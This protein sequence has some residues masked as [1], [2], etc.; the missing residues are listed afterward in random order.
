MRSSAGCYCCTISVALI[1]WVLVPWLVCKAPA[2]SE[3]MNVPTLG[4][5]TATV[6][7]Q[8]PYAGIEPPLKVTI[9]LPLVAV[10]V[11]LHVL[12]AVPET[13]MPLGN[14]SVSGAVRLDATPAGFLRVMVSAEVLPLTM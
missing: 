14:K 5:V 1:P 3:L 10:T 7:V 11:P 6:T 13:V 4:T 8:E 2:G 12:L 9:E